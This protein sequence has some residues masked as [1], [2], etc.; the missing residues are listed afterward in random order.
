MKD[1]ILNGLLL[2]TVAAAL[3]LTLLRGAPEEAGAPLPLPTSLLPGATAT[4]HPIDA[5]RSQRRENRQETEALLALLKDSPDLS[6]EARAQ[7]EQQLGQ[8]AARRETELAVEAALAAKGMGRGLCVCRDGAVTVFVP[9]P[10]SAQD[11]ALL[12]DWVME[13]SG[14]S[15]ENIRISAC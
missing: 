8:I 13:I 3:G 10:L 12:L 4:P 11:A 7:A 14:V 5:Y 15:K 9:Q 1:R 2:L 6:P